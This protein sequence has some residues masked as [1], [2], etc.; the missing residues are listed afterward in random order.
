LVPVRV[1]SFDFGGTLAFEEVEDWNAYHEILSRL[2]VGVD[3][4]RVKEAYRR[5][6]LSWDER[7]RRGEIWSEGQMAIFVED[8][9]RFL[10]AGDRSIVGRVLDMWASAKRFRAYEDAREALEALRGRGYRLIVISNVS[11][12]RNLRAY[13]SQI[14]LGGYFEC[15][16]AS[17]TVG[18]EKPSR[19]I[20]SIASRKA[21][22]SP[23]EILHVGDD[24]EAD[25]LGAIRAGLRAVL[26]D[27]EGKHSGAGMAKVRSLLELP[28]ILAAY[29]P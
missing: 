21:G 4:E 11:S 23:E 29:E 14:N 18:F 19:E 15:L 13:L 27:R 25:Y 9:L 3:V 22:V 7:R 8:I 20:F 5:A 1:V 12:E 10:G 24:Y 16:V 2:G 6:K 17:G 28:G 26:L